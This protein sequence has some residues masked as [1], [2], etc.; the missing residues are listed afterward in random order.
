[1]SILVT[2]VTASVPVTGN[3]QFKAVA[4]YGDGT[5]IDVTASSA[6]SS[7]TPVN[8]S[9]NATS[10]LA[11]GNVAGTSSVITAT[12]DSLSGSGTLTVT[13]A[14]SVS[15]VV[16]PKLASIPVTGTQQYTAIETFSDATT[17]DRTAASTWTA[18][19]LVPVSTTPVATIDNTLG[20]LTR[21][22]ATGVNPGTS[23]ITAAYGVYTGTVGLA[24]REAVLTVTTAT[25]ESF[26]VTPAT[27]SILVDGTQQY[28]AIET[29]SDT[30]TQDRTAASTWT[31]VDLS[32]SGVATIS[33]TSPTIGV[34]TGNAAGTS[35]IT[36]A[37]G[38]YTGTVGL[39]DREAVL[40]V[41]TTVPPASCAGPGP[42]DMGA[43]A[44]FGVLVGPAGGATFTITNPTSVTGDT[45]AAS[46]I[47]AGGVSALAGTKYTG[48]D[49]PY[50][51][52]KAAML[53]AIGCASGR[54]CT[55]TYATGAIDFGGMTLAPGVHCVTG[56]MSVGSNLTI[57]TPGVYIFRSS[58]ALDTAVNVNVTFGSGVNASNTFLFWVP[59]GAA[60]IK[61][62]TAFKGTIMPDSS[63][64]STMNATATLLGG[65][66]FSNSDVNVDTNTISIP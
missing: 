16:T 53:T 35:T 34:A 13:Y 40:T 57:S 29:F 8:A 56:A 66:L 46:Y 39:A 10:G 5:S 54:A 9:V 63:A 11:T 52:A 47:P 25:S 15:F 7:G 26:K 60:T 2:P 62:G 48:V 55:V 21:G 59:S 51:A 64:A 18:V 28:T 41:T 36:A 31:A 49:A 38:V 12:F 22:R 1:V 32:G 65:R 27:A 19:D 58:G 42:V 4:T 23:T 43:A 3:Q 24:D 6:W 61:A 37:Y 44:S 17:Q 33:N 20:S 14:T 30:T 45:G 50:V